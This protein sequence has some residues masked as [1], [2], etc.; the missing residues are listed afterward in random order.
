[1]IERISKLVWAFGLSSGLGFAAQAEIKNHVEP[2]EP[3]DCT[4][5]LTSGEAS[6][7]GDEVA[8]G[9]D[10]NGNLIFNTTKSGEEFNPDL[11]T[12]AFPKTQYLGHYFKVVADDDYVIVRVNDK[13]PFAK[14]KRGKP[15]VIDLSEAAA[16]RIDMDGTAR[17]DV[18]LCKN[19]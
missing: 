12:A 13:G 9:R 14:D 8:I 6:W 4:T 18:Y 15:R 3:E 5:H 16:K 17:V 19:S 1:M 10:K 11:Y 7:Y 2:I